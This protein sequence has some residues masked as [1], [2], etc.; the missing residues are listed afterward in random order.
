METFNIFVLHQNRVKHGDYAYI[1]EGRLHKFLN[2]VIWGHEH[3]C[4]LTPEQNVE[5]GYFISQPGKTSFS[6][7]HTI[8]IGYFMNYEYFKIYI[9]VKKW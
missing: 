6:C 4:R 8:Y 5:G 9:T 7:I 2:L 3:E 1:P